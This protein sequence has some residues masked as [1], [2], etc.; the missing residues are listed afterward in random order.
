MR[1]CIVVV[2][3]LGAVVMAV[4]PAHGSYLRKI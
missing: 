4:E 3:V 2:R 1:L